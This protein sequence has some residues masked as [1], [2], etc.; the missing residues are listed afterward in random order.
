MNK[1]FKLLTAFSMF[2]FPLMAFSQ[3]TTPATDS[4]KV[5]ASAG[6]TKK[7]SL[8]TKTTV[9]TVKVIVDTVVKKD[10]YTEYYEAFRSRGGKPVPDGMQQV[11]IALKGSSGCQCFMGQI[12]VVGGKVKP[13][14]Q[15]QQESGEYH[16]I[17]TIGK[18]LDAAF[19]SSMTPDELYTIKD[20]M[21]IVFRT[22][23]N[24][25][26]RL[27]FYKFV[28]KGVQVNKSAPP[29]SELLKE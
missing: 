20:A 6:A 9:D 24:E 18:K 1:Y 17:S 10:C 25:Y 19:V 5:A 15:I 4:A 21:S 16:S 29:P 12:E 2:L 7:D 8:F 11:I 26:G 27:F 22:A 14:L 13:P 28:N 23:D 3:V